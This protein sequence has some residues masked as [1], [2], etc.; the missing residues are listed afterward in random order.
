VVAPK[1]RWVDALGGSVR[2]QTQENRQMRAAMKAVRDLHVHVHDGFIHQD[3]CAHCSDPEE[4]RWASWP[5]PT[6]Q[7]LNG[8]AA[9]MGDS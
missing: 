1:T 4:G 7:A 5:C 9:E 2:R 6:I 8:A 3:V